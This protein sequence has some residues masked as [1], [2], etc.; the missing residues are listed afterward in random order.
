MNPYFHLVSE[1]ASLLKKGK[2]CPLGGFQPA[3]RPELPEDA[4]KALFFAPHPDDECIVG[5][6]ALRLLREARMNVINVAVTQGSNKQRQAERFGELQGACQ[7]LGFGLIPT[8]PSGLERINPKTRQQD[9]AHW[10]SAVKII[11]D[12]L[13]RNWPRVILFPHEQDWNTTHVGTHF[14]VMDALHQI[15]GRLECYLVETEFWGQM[16]DPNLMVEISG[17]D[18]ADLMSATSFHVGEVRRNPYHVLLP[19]W[20]LDNVRRGSELV[21]GQGGTAPDFSF[22]ALYRLRK[23]SQGSVTR[24][25]E[26]GKLLSRNT[27]AGELFS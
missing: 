19:A 9:P 8:G 16:A 2:A 22:A 27:N 12:I 7:Y 14:L 3:P 25:L 20:M 15:A 17:E 4:A 10:A 5:G 23:W 18:L 26:G 1:Y 6:L 24:V 13:A 11:A 21:G